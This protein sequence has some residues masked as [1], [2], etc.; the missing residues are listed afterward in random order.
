MENSRGLETATLFSALKSG[1]AMTADFLANEN[2]I[3]NSYAPLFLKGMRNFDPAF[4][5]YRVYELGLLTTRGI[6]FSLS[7]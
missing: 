1:P 3:S 5:C 2:S 4:A 6:T 7:S